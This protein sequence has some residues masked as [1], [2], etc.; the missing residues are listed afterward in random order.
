MLNFLP[1]SLRGVL[2]AMLLAL[3]VLVCAPILLAFAVIKLL[4]PAKPVRRVVDRILNLIAERWVANNSAWIALAQRVSWHVEGVSQLR[5]R[6]WYLVESN[7]Q[8]WVDI[9]VLQKVF[10]RRIPLLKFFLKQQLIFV[11]VIGIAWWALDFPFMKRRS[12]AWLKRHPER[13]GEDLKTTR[14][15]CE[16]FS[17]IP[18]SVM[19]FLE[20]TRFTRQKHDAQGSPYTHLLRPKA[21]GIA[22]AL[23]AMG[24]KFES[25]LDVTIF[26]PD[27]APSLWDFMAGRVRRV[28]VFVNEL[29]IPTHLIQGDYTSDPDFRAKVQA[30]VHDLWSEKDARLAQLR[31]QF[32]PNTVVPA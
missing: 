19:N 8:S 10:N 28:M 16:K 17:L 29:P 3:N 22:L 1:A 30:W 23:N 15:A 9:F 31:L 24:E 4:I 6:G 2:S 26:Y 20:G 12:E 25:M 7:H 27:G 13:R 5:Y 32:A 14:R 11:P 21:G 18:T